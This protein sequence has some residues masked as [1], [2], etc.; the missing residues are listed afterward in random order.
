[1]RNIARYHWNSPAQRCAICDGQF[2]L[3]RHYVCRTA[4]CSRKCADRL[5]ARRDDDRRWLHQT[6]AA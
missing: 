1:M 3:A 6:Q 2:G 4:I 5:R